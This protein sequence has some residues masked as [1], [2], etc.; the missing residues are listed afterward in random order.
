MQLQFSRQGRCNEWIAG[1]TG[2]KQYRCLHLASQSQQQ[3]A[4][5]VSVTQAIHPS[6]Q[7]SSHHHAIKGSLVQP[8]Q[9]NPLLPF[10][11]SPTHPPPLR[12]TLAAFAPTAVYLPEL[13]PTSPPALNLLQTR[14]RTTSESQHNMAPT[15]RVKTA[16]AASQRP[17]FPPTPSGSEEYSDHDM[18]PDTTYNPSSTHPRASPYHRHAQGAYPLQRGT[19]CLSC[20]K[21]KM[22]RVPVSLDPYPITRLPFPSLSHFTRN[23]M[24]QS[25]FANSVPRQIAPPIVNTTM[26]SPRHALSSSRRRSN[27]LSRDFISSKAYP[28]FL[29]SSNLPTLVALYHTLLQHQATL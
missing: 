28:R 12:A 9:P 10:P 24:A 20:R 29:L 1:D 27:A 7:P 6:I 17:P 23:A 26:A 15:R 18:D 2:Y 3:A 19:A 22:V 5:A 14:T 8:T 11:R 4:V 21:R 25:P 13:Y 16:R